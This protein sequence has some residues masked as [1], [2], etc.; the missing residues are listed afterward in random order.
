MGAHP[1]KEY[2]EEIQMSKQVIKEV[3][4][5]HCDSE[6]EA[7]QTVLE[8]K[9]QAE[10][11]AFELKKTVITDKTKKPTN[12]NPMPEVTFHVQLTKE[13]ELESA[14]AL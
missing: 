6:H 12:K 14:F 13:Y 11:G 7:D 10:N 5:Y 1:L 4:T 9:E 2:K 8:A 3:I